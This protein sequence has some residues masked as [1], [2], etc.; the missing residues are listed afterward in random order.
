MIKTIGFRVGLL[1]GLFL[2][3]LHFGA[4]F[5]TD[6]KATLDFRLWII[7]LVAYFF[8]GFFAA[9]AQVPLQVQQDEPLKG[10]LNASRG[11]GMIISTTLWA[12]IILRGLISGRSGLFSGIGVIL[13]MLFLVID[14]MISIGLSSLGGSI[15]IKQFDFNKYE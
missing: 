8:A 10:T 12:Y 14:F 4:D 1:V 2:L 15:I 7:Q 11:A 9:K 5:A 13:T 3:I 6:W